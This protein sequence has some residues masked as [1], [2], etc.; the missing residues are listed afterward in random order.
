MET[1]TKEVAARL[2]RGVITPV[3]KMVDAVV[4]EPALVAAIV[5]ATIFGTGMMAGIWLVGSFRKRESI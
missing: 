1:L 5:G 2:V 3:P 4:A